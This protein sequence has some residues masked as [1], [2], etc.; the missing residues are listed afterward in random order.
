MLWCYLWISCPKRLASLPITVSQHQT[1]PLHH[2]CATK[3][4]RSLMGLQ[5][6][7]NGHNS[8]S[9]MNLV[10]YKPIIFIDSCRKKLRILLL[11]KTI[12]FGYLVNWLRTTSWLPHIACS[13]TQRLI[14]YMSCNRW[15]VSNL[16]SQIVLTIFYS[17]HSFPYKCT[18]L[19]VV[20]VVLQEVIQ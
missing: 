10:R 14:R 11:C 16:H 8:G 1:S 2:W 18:S 3:K 15:I 4:T 20:F 13:V 5:L 12:I 6:L 7:E 9:D 19:H 17:L